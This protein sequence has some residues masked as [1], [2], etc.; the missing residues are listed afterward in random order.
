MPDPIRWISWNPAGAEE[1]AARLAGEGFEVAPDRPAPPELLRELRARPPRA[2]VIDLSRSPSMGRDVGVQL[3]LRE[4][5]RRVPLVF[6]GGAEEKIA[7]VRRVLPDATYTTWAAIGGA[8]RRAIASPPRDPVKPDHALTGYSGRPLPKK[9]GIKPGSVTALVHAPP[10]F[11]AAALADLPAGARLVARPGGKSTL[12]V[13]FVRSTA[14]LERALP[15]ILTQ[16]AAGPVWIAWPKKAS[17]I[18]SDLSDEVVRRAGL[19]AGLVDFKVCAIDATWSGLC[20]AI[21][22]R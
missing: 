7:D 22:K 8:L 17:G 21:R 4:A 10:G 15:R 1:G 19:D 20:F 14:E 13:W 6:V 12:A 11:A 18:A 9:L 16:A 3:R 2:V 5:T